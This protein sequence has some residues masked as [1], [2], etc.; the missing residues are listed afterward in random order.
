MII[1]GNHKTFLQAHQED[2]KKVILYPRH[3]VKD[4]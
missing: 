2:G 1:R 3:F 4:A